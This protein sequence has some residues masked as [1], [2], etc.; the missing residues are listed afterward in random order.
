MGKQRVKKSN[1]KNRPNPIV[2]A[3]AGMDQGLKEANI[4]EEQVLPVINK[5][6]SADAGERSWA[7]ACI[8]NLVMSG[9]STRKLVLSKRIVP[10]LLERL[11]DDN[12]EVIEECLGTLRNLASVEPTLVREYYNRDILT[13]LA[14]LLPRITETIDLVLKNAPVKDEADKERRQ[15]IWDFAENYIYIIWGISEESDKYIRAVNRLNLI[16]FFISF[17]SAAD[18]IPNRVVV[19]AGQCLTTLTEDNKDIYIEFQNHPEYINMLFNIVNK[20]DKVLVRVLACAILMNIKEVVELSGSWAEEQDALSELNKT[21]MPILV[22]CLDFDMQKAADQTIAATQSGHVRTAQ[23]AEEITPKPK[24]P[25]TDEEKYIQGVEDH[26]STVQ[27]ALELLAEMCVSQDDDN[28]GWAE[29]AEE[30]DAMMEGEE[31]MADQVNEDNID[32]FIERDAENMMRDADTD[33]DASSN[34]ILHSFTFEVIPALIKLA[35]PTSLSYIANSPS[36]TVSL[37]LVL[38]HE[39]ALECFNNFLLAINDIPSKPW[40]KQNAT[41][42]TQAWPWLFQIAHQIGSAPA[43]AER[44]STLEIIVGCLWSLGRGLG[45]QIPL[46]PNDVPTL[47]GAYQAA[48]ANSSMRIKVIGC[49]G[50]IA[51]RQGDVAT[52]KSIGEFI[53]NCL[54]DMNSSDAVRIEALNLLYDVYS[55]EAFDY[56]LPVFVQGQFLGHLKQLV[57]PIR[58]MVKSIDRRKFFDLRSRADEA[59]MNLVAFIKYKASERGGK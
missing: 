50:P 12:Q 14:S 20:S 56:D 17:L 24:Q 39:R 52:N 37:A 29:A 47:C 7:A 36:P 3:T 35:T 21:V 6:S 16:T 33:K 28:D 11:T 8:S 55:D 32:D 49:L 48:A 19:A 13:V 23:E 4:Q 34:P 44:D 22:S 40:F 45:Q 46:Q 10:V 15:S 51:A 43:S 5:L 27:L 1:K 58:K 18:Q 54:R 31:E 30:D 41:D 42:A 59:L 9:E 2:R 53:M 38:T 25:L 57:P 26:L